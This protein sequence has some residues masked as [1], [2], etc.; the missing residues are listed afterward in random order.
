MHSTSSQR[1]QVSELPIALSVFIVLGWYAYG[2]LLVAPYP[3]FSFS[4]TNGRVDEI[5]ADVN[6][7]PTL[8]IGDVLLKVGDVTFDEYQQ[9]AHVIFFDGAKAGD[10]V[11]I[12][13]QRDEQEIVI[14]WRFAG[15]DRDAFINRFFNVWWLAFV[16]WFA[17]FAGQLLIRPKN[18]LRTLFIAATY[19]TALW[20]IF[21]SLSS[22]RLWESSILLHAT[23]WLLFPV[24]LHLHWAFPRPLKKLPQAFWVFV[25]VLGFSLAAAEV[26]QLLP[27]SLY[28]LGFLM[29]VIGSIILQAFHYIKQPHQRRSV[30]ILAISIL[31]AFAPSILLGIFIISS[32]APVIAPL[33]LL[34]MPFMPL[35]YFYVVYSHQSGGLEIRLNR[36][37]A[38]YAYLILLG[39]L[40]LLLVIPIARMPISHE[41]WIFVAMMAAAATGI[42]SILLFPRF[43]ALVDQR[44]LGIKLPYQRLPETYSSRI[45]VSASLSSLLALLEDEIFPSLLVRQYAFL[46]AS[47]KHLT[48]LLA[49][50]TPD[51]AFDFDSLTQ[52]AGRYLPALSSNEDWTRLI[53]PLKVGDKTLGFWLLGR[54]DPDDLYPQVEIPILQSLA[55]QTAVALSN[56]LQSEHLRNFYQTDIESIENE[57]K[58]ISRDLHDAVLNPLA[59]MRNSLDQRTLPQSFLSTYEDIKKRLREIINDLR[60]PMLDQGLAY[61]LNEF[62]E[63]LREKNE[64]VNIVLSLQAGAERLPEKMEEH[65]YH[66]AREACE[67]ALR[68][69]DART[70]TISGAISNDHVDL[71][72]ED[73]GKGF[74]SNDDLNTLIANRHFGLANMKERAHIIGAEMEIRSRK[75]NGTSIRIT[76]KLKS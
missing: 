62:V 4:P 58:R 48:P 68:H 43:Q 1:W 24:Y 23:T 61:A 37:I 60:P 3:G 57:R 40:L 8:H 73:D 49:K 47:E 9:D 72:I 36:F 16:F 66:I 15:F 18:L 21:G 28:A 56:I 34:S 74:D 75:N 54:R 55:N 50:N 6:L 2:I 41:N 12:T 45:A 27:K 30:G 52:K 17:G 7:E 26:F 13:V 44:F 20:L 10:V 29:A 69:A 42:L 19:L 64:D 39:V 51:D 46:Q 22:R 63:D 70:L 59:T 71:S 53:L 5:Q 67:N 31:I 38:L 65:F 14:P 32:E 76:W 33:G 11:Q 25:Y 35:M